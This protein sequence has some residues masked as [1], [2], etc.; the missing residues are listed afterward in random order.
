MMSGYSTAM[1]APPIH[2][3]KTYVKLTYISI[4]DLAQFVNGEDAQARR[5]GGGR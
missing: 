3:A 4:V 2:P 1:T 5:A